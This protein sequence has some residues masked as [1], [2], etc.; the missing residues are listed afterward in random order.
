MHAINAPALIIKYTPVQKHLHSLGGVLREVTFQQHVDTSGSLAKTV[1]RSATTSP[2]WP[3]VYIRPRLLGLTFSLQLVVV[4]STSCLM[5]VEVF[6]LESC[7]SCVKQYCE[8]N[9]AV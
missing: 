2:P 7:D 1:A 9:K 3:D 5:L 8:L 4:E 6:L